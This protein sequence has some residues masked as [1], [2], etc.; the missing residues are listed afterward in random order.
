[1]T[2]KEAFEYL[3]SECGIGMKNP[4]IALRN[5]VEAFGKVADEIEPSDE[6]VKKS[7]DTMTGPLTV[8][9]KVTGEEVS[10]GI[11]KFEEP[12]LGGSISFTGVPGFQ[13]VGIE[14]PNKSGTMVLSSTVENYTT[15]EHVVGRWI[16]GSPVYQ[17]SF[18]LPEAIAI[19]NTGWT[20]TGVTIPNIN[21]V[22]YGEMN[23]NGE[24]YFACS[25]RAN[26]SAIEIQTYYDRAQCTTDTV[27]TIRY[28]KVTT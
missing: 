23:R 7:G 4:F 22:I 2:I 13:H 15:A 20:S 16:D 9:G 17:K 5:L 1:M 14:V 12:V 26:D 24:H 6:F 27:I 19:T 25:F 18:T 3:S 28:T 21:N 10:A 11:F 8:E